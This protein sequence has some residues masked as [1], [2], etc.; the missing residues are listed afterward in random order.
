[1]GQQTRQAVAAVGYANR[2]KGRTMGK[3]FWK[4]K[5]FWVNA[6]MVVGAVTGYLPV[7]QTTVA[8]GGIANI[9]LRLL[10]NQPISLPKIN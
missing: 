3:S 10:T 1:M 6:L 2:I 7:N 9:G 4:S 8:I 5:T